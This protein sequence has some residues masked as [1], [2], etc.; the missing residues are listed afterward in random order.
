MAQQKSDTVP[1]APRLLFSASSRL[2]SNTV[3]PTPLLQSNEVESQLNQDFDR[4]KTYHKFLHRSL[5]HKGFQY[6]LGLNIDPIKFQPFGSCREG[7]LYFTDEE[8]LARFSEF[9]TYIAN[10]KIPDDARVYPDPQGHKWKA[11]KIIVESYCP[12]Q[13]HPLFDDPEWC[14]KAV[15]IEGSLLKYMKKQT[16]E[17]C[18]GAVKQYP[19][20]LTYVD[21]QLIDAVSEHIINDYPF[22]L[23]FVRNQTPDICLKAVKQHGFALQFVRNQTHEIC[24]EAVKKNGCA[25][26]FVEDRTQKICMEAVKQ[27]PHALQF[28]RN[29]T[30]EM[31]REAIKRNVTVMKY[32]CKQYKKACK[33]HAAKLYGR[34]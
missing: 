19:F 10:I 27:N 34:R 4:R 12:A 25:L 13:D 21:I 26:E 8:N 6:E 3:Q 23:Q 7:G 16:F 33:K 9:G 28:V 29:Q 31:C 32:V 5:N 17:I 15:K 18:V 1:R 14:L 24:L 20:A 2:Q 11:D 30:L 22:A